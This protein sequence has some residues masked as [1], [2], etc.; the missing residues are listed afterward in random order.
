SGNAVKNWGMGVQHIWFFQLDDFLDAFGK[1]TCTT[2][3]YEERKKS[4]REKQL[5]V[6]TNYPFHGF[7]PLPVTLFILIRFRKGKDD[8]LPPSCE[9]GFKNTL[10]TKTVT[11][12]R[13]DTML[14]YM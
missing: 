4:V 13:A 1:G 5:P 6:I 7:R 11:A 12:V 2:P 9:L 14:D 10:A 8:R 3:E